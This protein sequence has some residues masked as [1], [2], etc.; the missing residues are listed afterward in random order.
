MLVGVP[1][2]IKDHEYRVGLTPRGVSLLCRNGHRVLVQTGAGARAGCSDDAYRAAGANTVASAADAFAADLIV[3]VKEIQP[4]EW[5]LLHAGQLLFT[6]LHLAANPPLTRSLLDKGVTAIAYETV[7]DTAGGLPLLVPMS[8]IAGRL[9]IQM[10]AWALQT[11]NGGSGTLLAGS[12]GV[13]PAS[14]VILGGGTVGTNAARIA[15]GMGADV[16]ILDVNPVRLRQLD[17]IFGFR[18]KTG[19]ADAGSIAERVSQADLLVGSVLIPGKLAPKLVSRTMLASMVPGS[20]FV[21]VAIDQ[22]GCADTSRPTT[23]SA[24][25]YVEEDV[26]HCCVTNMPSA[27]ART[28]T[29]ALAQVTLPYV[30]E[31]ADRGVD[32]IR[33][34]TALADG[35]QIHRG[36]VT[37]A[38]VA[39]DLGLPYVPPLQALAA[40]G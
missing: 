5:D 17:E 7:T 12:P 3:K 27:V 13:P 14:V 19:P 35:M 38:N 26:V 9:A 30:L 31:L 16:T 36:N 15:L 32:A 8:I 2:E 11:A 25:L 6:Y 29:L 37:H 4:G 24:P 40:S 21:D 39:N 20:V 22:G 18:L 34:S 28:A 10:G 1:R 23:H 33:N